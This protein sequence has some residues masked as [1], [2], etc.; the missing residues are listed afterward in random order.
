MAFKAG[1]GLPFGVNG[2]KKK[3][4]HFYF[5]EGFFFLNIF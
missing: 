4:F 1:Q 2:K 5:W 3:A